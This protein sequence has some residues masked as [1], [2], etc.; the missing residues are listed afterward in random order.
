VS[1]AVKWSVTGVAAAVTFGVG[2]WLAMAVELPFLPKAEA[3]RWVV[4]AAFAGVMATAVVA[5]GAW[6]AGRENRPGS[7]EGD[8]AGTG[9]QIT[10]SPGSI[11]FGLGT[12]AKTRDITVNVN[13]PPASPASRDE[14]G[15]PKA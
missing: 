1:R 8:P 9:Q 15:D 4:A 11:Q 13:P 5:C 7:G 6:W 14:V 12:R 10:A 3:D 2:L